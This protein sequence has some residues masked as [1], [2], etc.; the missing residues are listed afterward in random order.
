MFFNLVRNQT[1]EIPV[2]LCYSWRLEYASIYQFY[3]SFQLNGLAAFAALK[4]YTDVLFLYNSIEIAFVLGTYRLFRQSKH[5]INI[6][7]LFLYKTASVLT[8]WLCNAGDFWGH[9][10]NTRD[11][12]IKMS[13]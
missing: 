2:S 11:K 8:K 5:E 10:P 13:V 6:I 7:Y 3:E 4:L 9:F 1:V 12:S